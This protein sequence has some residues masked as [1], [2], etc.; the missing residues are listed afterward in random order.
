MTALILGATAGLGQS[1]A[2]LLAQRGDALVLIGREATDLDRVAADLRARFRTHVTTVVADAKR[3]EPLAAAIEGVLAGTSI[4]VALFPVGVSVEDDTVGADAALADEL[5]AVNLVGVM[6]ASSVVAEAMRHQGHGEIVGFSSVA[7]SRGR[8]RNAAYAAAKRGLE[9]WFESLRADLAG[10][11]VGVRWYVLGYVAT[12][13]SYGQ[14]LP[15]PVASPD[16]IAGRV[17]DELG[18]RGGQ[19][20]APR[21][22]RPVAFA[23]R[24]IPFPIFRKV[25]T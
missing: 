1:L 11:G 15:L 18:S 17:I 10:D 9:S 13:L 7:A 14:A 3:P 6:A 22:W 24:R 25:K 23:V 19:R 2:S 16:A 8:A 5:V 20:Y 12:N 4:D 21:W